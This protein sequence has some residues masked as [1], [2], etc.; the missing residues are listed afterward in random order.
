MYLHVQ[1]VTI[2]RN[3]AFQ[4]SAHDIQGYEVYVHMKAVYVLI[5]P[6]KSQIRKDRDQWYKKVHSVMHLFMS[7]YSSIIL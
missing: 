2:L 3:L 5:T 6:L 7:V 1:L 4:R